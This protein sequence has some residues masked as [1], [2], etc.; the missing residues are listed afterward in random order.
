MLRNVLD[1]DFAVH[2]ISVTSLR[3][4][5]LLFDF[6][7]AFPSM[8]HSFMWDVLEGIGIPAQYVRMLQMFYTGNTHKIK[9]ANE[10]FESITVES[11]VRQGCPLSPLL[12]AICADI[13]LRE[14]AEALRGHELVR[15]FADDTA[16]AVNDYVKVIPALA[17]LFAEFESI[18]CLAL[19]I[20]KTVFIPLW[21]YSSERGLRNLITELAPSWRDIIIAAQGKY[22]GFWIGPGAGCQSWT[23]PLEKFEKRVLL[24]AKHNLGLLLT[25]ITF[26]VFICSVLS[27]VMQLEDL[28]ADFSSKLAWALR[29]LVPGPGNWA[30]PADLCSL[31]EEFGFPSSFTNPVDLSLAAKLRVIETVAPDCRDRCAEL[32]FL[33]DAVLQGPFGNWHRNSYFGILSRAE[34][35][36]NRMGISRAAVRRAISSPPSVGA[37]RSF[38]A[39]AVSLIRAKSGSRDQRLQSKIARWGFPGSAADSSARIRSNFALIHR[40]C[41]PRVAAAY[42][43]AVFNGWTTCRRMRHAN[44]ACQ[45]GFGRCLFGCER[46]ADSLEHYSVCEVV[47]QFINSP[48]PGGMGVSIEPSTSSFFLMGTGSQDVDKIRTGL[49][50]YA[51]YRATNYMRHAAA[52]PGPRVDVVQLLRRWSRRGAES[53]RSRQLLHP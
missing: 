25:A 52:H 28:P 5:V 46:G 3:G 8:D 36:L 29:R 1:V 53:S 10:Y 20:K 16:A 27:F 44:A 31:K 4:A 14:I 41:P 38:Q 9:I 21:K 23:K 11:G 37:R 43:R 42:L 18:S 24:W 34:E 26:N 50:L 32:A 45:C 12:F 17:T 48:R 35:H 6:R 7:A 39:T 49:A 47:W 19:N 33:D 51:V 30:T 13:L 40:W 15:A 2:K 22:L